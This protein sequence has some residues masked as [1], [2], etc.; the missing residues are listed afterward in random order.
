MEL[1][2]LGLR[3]DLALIDGE[4]LD[5]G[6]YLVVRSPKEQSFYG[7]NLLVF[8]APPQD[9]DLARWEALFATEFKDLPGVLHRTLLWDLCE[10]EGELAPFVGEGYRVERSVVLGASALVL[11]QHPNA[12]INIRKLES[13]R[14][15]RELLDLQVLCRDAEHNEENFRAYAEGRLRGY[16]ERVDAGSGAWYSAFVG[17]QQVAS[18]GMFRSENAGRFQVVITHPS[19]RR[20]GIC[21]TLVHHVAQ[22]TLERDEID[23]LLM[24]ADT[25]YHAARIYES[26]GFAPTEHLTGL[27]HWPA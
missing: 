23:S 7:G 9:G 16:R 21:G 14:D 22:L 15:W 19:F 18:L 6:E 27:W 4:I 1:R 24:V 3:S 10:R 26:V 8:N 17:D 12:E 25:E 13:E 11:P 5:R 2:S 20:R